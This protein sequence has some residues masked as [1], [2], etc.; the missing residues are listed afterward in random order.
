M[1]NTFEQVYD[2]YFDKS[3]PI[4]L[5]DILD[6]KKIDIIYV[7][8]NIQDT[9][10]NLTD[11]LEEDVDTNVFDELDM[12]SMSNEN[13]LNL[14]EEQLHQIDNL[15]LL[16]RI[17]KLDQTKLSTAQLQ[18]LRK[19][20]KEKVIIKEE[21]VKQLLEQLKQCDRLFI[22]P[23]SKNNNFLQ[24]HNLYVEDCLEILHQLEV[25]DYYASTKSINLN[26]LGH[27]LIIFEKD[28]ITLK[29]NRKLGLLVIYIKLD[30]TNSN[31][32]IAVAVSFH[33]ALG[34]NKQLY[35]KQTDGSKKESLDPTINKNDINEDIED[36][37]YND[38]W[39]IDEEED[40]ENYE[41][42]DPITPEQ[43][44]FANELRAFLQSLIDKETSDDDKLE[45]KFTSQQSFFMH[46]YEHCLADI[47][48]RKSTKNNI[49]Y[50]FNTVRGYSKYEQKLYN[51][52][53]QGVSNSKEQYD[54]IDDIFN[55]NEVNKK[56]TK[57]FEGNFTLFI[58]GIFG[59]RNSKGI[60]NFGIHAFSSNVTTN[61]TGGNTLDICILSSSPKTITLYPAD[62]S[63]IKKEL[64]RIIN[65]Y[66]Q[67]K[68]TPSS[69]DKKLLDSLQQNTFYIG[70]VDYKKEDRR[71]DNK[72]KQL[73]ERVTPIINKQK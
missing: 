57:L 26:N 6:K 59:L 35:H 70:S 32:N 28:S 34:L 25:T 53:K 56:F 42:D 33:E 16:D 4:H 19:A 23:T 1:S 58:S 63:T 17:A 68:L 43:E 41:E 45:E 38:D 9:H 18:K 66:S 12:L 60:V 67:L 11:S 30:L 2:M 15:E 72:I 21:D 5:G 46:Y 7:F 65:K 69:D 52:F 48:N 31:N 73:L 3:N 61:Y 50:D 39:I 44:S 22:A 71:D 55:V 64:I 62:A 14:P 51:I 10:F 36:V 20:Y 13:L 54:F 24:E 37:W 47:P 49:Y 29:D 27:D 8:D 40:I